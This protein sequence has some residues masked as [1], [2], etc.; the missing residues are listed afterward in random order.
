MAGPRG[1]LTGMGTAVILGALGVVVVGWFFHHYALTH[2]DLALEKIARRLGMNFRFGLPAELKEVLG[3]FR[4]IEN[5]KEKGGEFQA[6][7]NSISGERR[8]RK[9]AFFDFKWVTVSCTTRRSAWTLE[10]SHEHLRTHVRSAVAAQMGVAIQ[11]VLIRPE[12]LV[13]KAMALAGYDD[14]DFPS[15]PEFS[16]RFYVNSPDRAFAR[17]LVTPALAR[18]FL[19]NVRCTV[20]V[21]GPWLLLHDNSTMAS[22]EVA[23]LLEQASRIA[24]LITREQTQAR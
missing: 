21:V 13:D 15:M 11:P 22:G 5:V 8:G 23:R 12:N 14:V 19:E 10:D 3:R 1:R 16:K 7:I 17:R 4:A 20:D 24:D 2:L 18:F 6:G 9:V